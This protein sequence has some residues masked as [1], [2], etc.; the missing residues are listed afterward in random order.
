MSQPTNLRS[1]VEHVL[2]EWNVAAP[3]ADYVRLVVREAYSRVG[4]PRPI[5]PSDPRDFG[6]H[7]PDC[8]VTAE[9]NCTCDL[10]ARLAAS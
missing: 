9:D 1:A 10:P 2:H 7:L 5:D 6:Y 3:Q 8:A 4:P